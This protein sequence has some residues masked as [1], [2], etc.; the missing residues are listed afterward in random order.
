MRFS[1]AYLIPE[2][3]DGDSPPAEGDGGSDGENYLTPIAAK[4]RLSRKLSAAQTDDLS[5]LEVLDTKTIMRTLQGRYEA[6][7]L[8]VSGHVLIVVAPWNYFV[9]HLYLSMTKTTNMIIILVFSYL[10]SIR[11]VM[12]LPLTTVVLSAYGKYFLVS[13]VLHCAD[14]WSACCSPYIGRKVI[15]SRLI[16]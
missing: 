11:N 3:Q 4:D 16:I 6:G 8:Q 13:I 5:Q 10:L 7:N 14:N 1:G 2:G 9:F 12:Q 15:H